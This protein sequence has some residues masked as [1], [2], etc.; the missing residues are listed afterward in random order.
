[1]P[2]LRLKQQDSLFHIPA[3]I[4]AFF[5]GFALLPIFYGAFITLDYMA[6]YN[7]SVATVARVVN[8]EP[9]R[10][11]LPAERL[12]AISK[13]YLGPDTAQFRP[14]F[15]YTHENGE[16][17]IGGALSTVANWQL[18]RGEIVKIRYK[19]GSPDLA[20]PVTFTSFWAIPALF[21]GGGL[22]LLLV[23][24]TGMIALEAR[25]QPRR[26]LELR[27]GSRLNIGRFPE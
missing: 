3:P 19:R 22:A 26:P 16:K 13:G 5:V 17:H 27:R 23:I 7:N 8:I 1:M 6:F 20:Q 21:I 2:D 9:Q 10:R 11:A 15:F 18:Q 24:I 25:R 14:G 4:K 12:D